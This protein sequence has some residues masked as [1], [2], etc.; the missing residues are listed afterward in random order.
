M[1]RAALIAA[2]LTLSAAALA[3]PLDAFLANFGEEGVQTLSAHGYLVL[4]GR[5]PKR[6]LAA[7]HWKALEGLASVA[8]SCRSLSH[9]F[10]ACRAL[11]A[12]G[13]MTPKLHALADAVVAEDQERFAL[14]ASSASATEPEGLPNLFETAWGRDLA[15]RHRADEIEDPATLVKGYFEDVL[16]GPR[17]NADAVKHFL[18]VE[19]A[20]GASGAG[21]DARLAAD[22][23]RGAASDELR[24]TL[25]RYLQD[26]RR[27]RGLAVAHARV[28][29][30]TAEKETRR[31]LDALTALAGAMAG[32]PGLLAAL[33]GAV[34]G[35]PAPSG[36][37]K[38]RT[39][40]IHLQD[41]TR[42]GQYEL[43][44][45]ASVSG[46]YWVDGLEEGE[47]AEIDE[48]TF[49][50]TARGFAAVE[51]QTV[52]RRN[53]GPYPYERRLTIAETHPF[54]LVALISSSSGTIVAERAE[55]PIAPDFELS[56]KREAA[57]LQL[58]QTCD[59]KAAAVAFGALADLVGDAAKVKPQYRDLLDR[60]VRE[61]AKAAA[62]A[63]TQAKLADAVTAAR[64]DLSPQQ[65][66]YSAARTDAAIALARKLPPG[67]DAVLPEL[68]AQR[69]TISRRAADQAWFLKESADARSRQRACDSAGAADRWTSALAVLEVD[70]A[71][72]CG[73]VDAE[74][75]AAETGLVA[76]RRAPVWTET[77]GKALDK[78]ES[79][80]VPAKRL[81][82]LAP[83]IA[84]LSW[85]DD[86]DCRRDVLKRAQ[87]LADKSG[88][89]EL[90]PSASAA[91]GLLPADLTLGTVSQDVRRARGRVLEKSDA[92]SAPEETGALQSLPSLP[93]AGAPAPAQEDGK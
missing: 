8:S 17:P 19:A 71:A 72:R 1:K 38:L 73:K 16:A 50:Q 29:A 78:A 9:D 24:A 39:A 31:D 35:A 84:R 20:A 30:L 70:P 14:A 77:L 83:L 64:Q 15:A 32:K 7:V 2:S 47:S 34:S 68:F 85:L 81:A 55:V 92:A 88:A 59:P 54:A 61:R 82:L 74:A 93:G 76:A 5:G 40:G 43:G 23:A 89:D 25:R 57:A 46:A 3:A 27:R 62:D 45:Q 56:L 51:T 53:G 18:A 66:L 63:A 75:K 41:P 33:E 22:A 60:A 11:P 28:T 58:W 91:A 4:Q 13:A 69:A 80:P 65:C 48:T 79:E 44:D 26:E 52:K 10:G 42:L 21:A 87:R 90:G 36:A 49:V 67:C 86:A 6:R 12:D 37:P